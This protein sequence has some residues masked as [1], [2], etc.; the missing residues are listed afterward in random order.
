MAHEVLGDLPHIAILNIFYGHIG[1]T[2]LG[3]AGHEDCNIS[4]GWEV[5]DRYD[6]KWKALNID[7]LI[8]KFEKC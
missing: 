3:D 4:L 7:F 6:K 8:I 1:E 5:Q 2:N